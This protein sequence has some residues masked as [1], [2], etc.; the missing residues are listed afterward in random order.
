MVKEGRLIRLARGV[1]I[2]SRQD[3]SVIVMRY[4]RAI[5]GYL[6]PGAIITDRSA[7]TGGLTDGVLFLAHRGK[8]K[9]IRLPSLDVVVRSGLRPQPGDIPLPG[10][11]FQASRQRALLENTI[12]SR[13]TRYHVRR[14]LDQGELDSWID[15]LTYLE[16]GERIRSYLKSAERP[17]P[18][19]RGWTGANGE[20]VTSFTTVN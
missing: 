18:L 11:L 15:K 16:G 17:R 12:Q 10:G 7:V 1:Y 4:W 9:I 8:P 3:P 2:S 5:V 14:T 20:A 19:G 13:N 6:L